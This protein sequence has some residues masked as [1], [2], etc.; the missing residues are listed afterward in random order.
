MTK[1]VERKAI[2]WMTRTRIITSIALGCD[3]TPTLLIA[4]K[5]RVLIRN[6][7]AT[8]NFQSGPSVNIGSES[9]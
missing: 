7:S 2:F 3:S 8:E 6:I 9:E 5:V 1:I 4:I